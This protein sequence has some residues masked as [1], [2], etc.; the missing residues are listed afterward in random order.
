MCFNLSLMAFTF[1]VRV[2]LRKNKPTDISTVLESA[3]HFDAIY[4]LEANSNETPTSATSVSFIEALSRKFG[5]LMAWQVS[6]QSRS[7]PMNQKSGCRDTSPHKSSPFYKRNSLI[8]SRS[9]SQ[10]GEHRRSFSLRNTFHDKSQSRSVSN[11]R[12]V[13]FTGPTICYGC[14]RQGHTKVNRKNCWNCGYSQHQ[15]RNCPESKSYYNR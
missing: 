4:G 5:K 1:H 15:R 14:N 2:E 13:R 10:H 7:R 3:L 8:F 9:P 11:E 12:E 6:Y